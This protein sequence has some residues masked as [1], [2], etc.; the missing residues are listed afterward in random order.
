MKIRE[1]QRQIEHA[2]NTGDTDGYRRLVGQNRRVDQK[3]IELHMIREGLKA[4]ARR[5][6]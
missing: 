3:A 4:K 2:Y 6:F 5:W 1:W